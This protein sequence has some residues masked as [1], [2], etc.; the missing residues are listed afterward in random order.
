MRHFGTS[1]EHWCW[2]SN[3]AAKGLPPSSSPPSSPLLPSAAAE[4]R[5]LPAA[6]KEARRNASWEL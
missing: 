1:P 4:Q 3:V 5:Q 2:R 6:R